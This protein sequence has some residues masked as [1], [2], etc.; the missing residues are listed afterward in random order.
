MGDKVVDTKIGLLCW[1]LLTSE[2]VPL[3]VLRQCPSRCFTTIIR[4]RGGCRIEHR[5][6]SC[7]TIVMAWKNKGQ[8][9][10]LE[11]RKIGS[12]RCETTMSGVQTHTRHAH[13]IRMQV[14]VMGR[15]SWGG[16][17]G[18][19]AGGLARSTLT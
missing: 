9:C 8:M 7:R 4:E 11:L 14:I 15:H 1:V 12:D 13:H 19:C 3:L 6:F 18:A 16:R 5:G 10:R 17:Q 2:A